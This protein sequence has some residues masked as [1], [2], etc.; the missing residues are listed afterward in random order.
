MLIAAARCAKWRVASSSICLRDSSVSVSGDAGESFGK[1]MP[2]GF[3][4]ESFVGGS[5]SAV[6]VTAAWEASPVVVTACCTWS[7]APVDSFGRSFTSFLSAAGTF[8]STSWPSSRSSGF[9]ACR[10]GLDIDNLVISVK[11][12]GCRNRRHPVPG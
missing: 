8:F 12:G 10:S 2:S 1:E 5:L 11:V 7:S 3:S 4:S 6:S 9:S